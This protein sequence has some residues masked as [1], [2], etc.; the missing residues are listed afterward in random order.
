[1]IALFYLDKYEGYN[2]NIPDRHEVREECCGQMGRLIVEP[3]CN[4]A[5]LKTHA[6]LE[7][8]RVS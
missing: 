4:I 6:V 2:R 1:M 3:F 8:V 7:A 5:L